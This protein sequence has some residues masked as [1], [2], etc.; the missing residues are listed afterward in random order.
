MAILHNHTDDVKTR[1]VR[2]IASGY[3]TDS[4]EKA[5]DL[6]IIAKVNYN[7]ILKSL[8]ISSSEAHDGF[9]ADV[10]LLNE[11][12]EEIK[13]NTNTLLTPL[14][15]TLDFGTA[16]DNVECLNFKTRF[17]TLEKLI[18]SETNEKSYR[19]LVFVAL[20]IKAAATEAKAGVKILSDVNFIENI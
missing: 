20:K 18:L 4:K 8:K 14:K 13:Y 2:Y 11:D 7:T 16:L 1:E 19:G 10:V 6:I 15:A 17:D 9:K 3:T 5:D 12:R